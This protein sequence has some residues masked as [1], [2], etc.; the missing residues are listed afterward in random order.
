MVNKKKGLIQLAKSFSTVL[1]TKF[2]TNWKN[3]ITSLCVYLG[4]S[5]N[6]LFFDIMVHLTVHLVDKVQLCGL[7]HLCW[8]Y[9]LGR[10]M[11]LPKGYVHNHCCSEGCIVECYVA[12]KRL[13]FVLNIGLIM[14]SL[15][16]YLVTW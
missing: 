7:V 12:E 11:K 15:D 14:L 1:E 9:L 16:C 8:M 6:L 4:N 10:N 13:E 2:L 5:S 3:N